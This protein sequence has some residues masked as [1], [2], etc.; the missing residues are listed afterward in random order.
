MIA[1]NWIRR[2]D[3]A[4]VFLDSQ[5]EV[6]R[7]FFGPAERPILVRA[8]RPGNAIGELARS[9]EQ[10]YRAAL[11]VGP[12]ATPQPLYFGPYRDRIILATDDVGGKTLAQLPGSGP[13]ST[14]A[15][16]ALGVG[17]LKAILVFHH[18]GWL[19]RAVRPDH[20]IQD[21]T[22]RILLVGL[23]SARYMEDAGPDYYIL[24]RS[25][26]D[27][28][29]LAPEQTGRL[30]IQSSWR[31]DIYAA[32]A[33][34]Y[35][36]LAGRPAFENQDPVAILYDV[37]AGVPPSPGTF[38]DTPDPFLDAIVAK[39]MDK[40]PARRYQTVTGF[41]YDLQAAASP[42]GHLPEPGDHD[43]P[44][45]CLLGIPSRIQV[46][47]RLSPGEMYAIMKEVFPG[48]PDKVGTLSGLALATTGGQ[49]K[50]LDGFLTG[51]A[52][53]GS[54]WFEAPRCRWRVAG[55]V[56]EAKGL[57]VDTE[58]ALPGILAS[59][60][61]SNFRFLECAACAGQDF[62]PDAV[63][64]ILRS[65][66]SR[67][68]LTIPALEAGLIVPSDLAGRHFR[69][70][71]ESIPQRL[72]GG[73]E[74]IRKSAWH[75][76]FARRYETAGRPDLAIHH[77]MADPLRPHARDDALR[78]ALLLTQA[79][80][81]K[82]NDDP[83]GSLL[84]S[85]KARQA[86]GPVGWQDDPGLALEIALLSMTCASRT[87]DANAFE[88]YH[89]EAV[90]M[91]PVVELP[92]IEEA[93][94]RGLSA[95]GKSVEALAC[96]FAALRRLGLRIP[97]KP[98]R[99]GAMLAFV[100]TMVVLRGTGASLADLPDMTEPKARMVLAIIAA[101]GPSA[102]IAKPV[103][104]PFLAA[105]GLRLCRRYGFHPQSAVLCA[106]MGMTAI[107]GFGW[108]RLG[109]RFG[110]L[111]ERLSSRPSSIDAYAQ[112][113]LVVVSFINHW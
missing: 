73:L 27:R 103:I 68:E 33:V 62:D 57:Q 48:D 19:H 78:R 67:D 43:S 30:A 77:V 66:E 92:R 29:Y 8:S 20:V 38:G 50:D 95:M 32:G 90:R 106:A 45:Q 83:S 54:I 108:Y 89:S 47:T 18:A 53:E 56:L 94:V 112:S 10:Q 87:G 65:R 41:A 24:P 96:V 52:A 16:M 9:M 105:A 99:L 98:G 13:R 69:F 11:A 17:L 12:G 111:A 64:A 22:G 93:A 72:Y 104:I 14:Q 59:L 26:M 75:K 82:A 21:A 86:M 2:R 51:L 84:L 28:A 107:S 23:G 40:D 35:T 37:I 58:A 70:S 80:K 5:R 3:E 74:S 4:P 102:Y 15:A 61:E 55:A 63:A 36:L 85:Q 60:G 81:A 109:F 39:A 100:S 113:R 110:Q 49:A 34:L 1:D 79:G 31:T 101:A 7:G 88:R 71:H 42:S 44:D 91:A 46:R 97:G 6:Y 76:A 25:G